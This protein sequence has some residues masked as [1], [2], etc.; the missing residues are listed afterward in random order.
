[1][2]ITWAILMSMGASDCNK[3]IKNELNIPAE[4]CKVMLPLSSSK[5]TPKKKTSKPVN[6]PDKKAPLKSKATA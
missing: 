3:L 1:M 5:K 6:N 2:I 4:G